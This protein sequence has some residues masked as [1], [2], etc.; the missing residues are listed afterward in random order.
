[1][2]VVYS[3]PLPEQLVKQNTE[4]KKTCHEPL[5]ILPQVD[6]TQKR[7]PNSPKFMG[8][9][10]RVKLEPSNYRSGASFLEEKSDL[11]AFGLTMKVTDSGKASSPVV[12]D[13][14]IVTSRKEIHVEKARSPMLVTELGM[15]NVAK[16]VQPMKA[17]FPM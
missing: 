17:S 15:V 11:H 14:G 5:P 6:L 12:T 16:E 8:C 9:I 2:V 13:S 1:M 3:I 7:N 10:D 4:L